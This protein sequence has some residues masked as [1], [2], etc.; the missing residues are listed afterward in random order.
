MKLIPSPLNPDWLIPQGWEN[1]LGANIDYRLGG[2]VLHLLRVQFN[3][4]AAVA[5]PAKPHEHT[6]HQ[7]LY[8]QRGGGWLE[9][10]GV[11]H[12]TV[13]GSIF[14]IPAGVRHHF[15]PG[16]GDA[17]LCLALDFS[18]EDTGEI[19]LG[20]MPME[21]EVAVLLSLL[22]VETA[23]PFQVSRRD[24]QLLDDCVA[25]IV[26]ENEKREVGYATLIQSLLLRLIA[27][28]LRATQRAQGFGEHFRHTAWRYRL[29]T[30]RVHAIIREHAARAPELTLT[31]A[32]RT[33][34][35]S[36]NHLNRILRQQTGH[37]FH[38]LLLR[39]RLARARDLLAR[40]EMNVTEAAMSAG[41]N[42][43]NYFARAF[44]KVHGYPPSQL[45]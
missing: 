30:E 36:A 5:D 34:G 1:I 14:F 23:R 19:A 39:E 43:S 24:H 38:Q 27:L 37:T 17:P 15:I 16:P 32:A 40:G 41:F 22:H 21:N 3:Q 42:D 31:E 44:K 25:E 45:L 28:C 29:L 33:C 18:I 2:S 12:S 9:A 35:A 13:E 26:N 20:G 4:H 10:N 6:H 8:Y 7:I 11:T